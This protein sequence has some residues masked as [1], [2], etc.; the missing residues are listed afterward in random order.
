M[1]AYY[2]RIIGSGSYLPETKKTNADFVK[3]QFFKAKD[4]HSEKSGIDTVQKFEE[5][6]G[7]S[8]RRYAGPEDRVSTLAARAAAFA[9]EDAGIDP[10]SLD[11]IIV[12][13]NWG[14]I[15]P[16]GQHYDLL[17]NIAARVKHTLGI[18][19]SDCVAYD[20][21]FGCPG[22]LQGVIQADYYLRSGDAKRILV[23]GSDTLSRLLDPHDIDSMLFG[24]GAGAMIFEAT[25]GERGSKGILSHAS[26]S[27]CGP[28]LHFLR[29]GCS[30]N[31][32]L[33][34]DDIFIK[35]NGRSVFRYAMETL[36]KLITHC[37]EKAACKLQD[38]DKFLMHQANIKM[39]RLIA[40]RMFQEQGL[41]EVP[42]YGLPMIVRNMGNNSV[43][44]IPVLY[45]LIHRGQ[46]PGYSFS[47]GELLLFSS[48]G[49]GMH[50]NAFLYRM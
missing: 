1:S 10:E 13:H 8:E 28:E 44:S 20:V 17:P 42:A 34:E 30:F 32:A 45:D 38:V 16:G 7:I 25:V 27:D 11:Y 49:A 12:A 23:I 24:D 26:V 21:L 22:W 15:L 4:E 5:I 46:L 9:I 47:E 39:V 36:P 37:I 33:P 3:Q 2:S 31:S 50:A 14:D 19:R 40:E 43:A 6:A 29:M 35:M 48:V 41:G 18:K